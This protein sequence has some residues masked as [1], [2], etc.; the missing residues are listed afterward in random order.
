M[1]QKTLL[2]EKPVIFTETLEIP[3]Y[4]VALTFNPPRNAA[5]HRAG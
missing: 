3:S 4:K 1:T 2:K 5:G